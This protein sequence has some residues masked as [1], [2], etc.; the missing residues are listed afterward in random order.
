MNKLL[1]VL[2]FLTVAVMGCAGANL[3]SSLENQNLPVVISKHDVNLV[4]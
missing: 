2:S 1:I 4:I 3:T